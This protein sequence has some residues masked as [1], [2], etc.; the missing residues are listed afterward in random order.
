MLD[1]QNVC[2]LLQKICDAKHMSV[3]IKESVK[4]GV[5]AGTGAAVGGLV[6]GPVGI[7]IGWY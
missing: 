3:T 2:T 4:G 1:V 6:G 5:V 7:F